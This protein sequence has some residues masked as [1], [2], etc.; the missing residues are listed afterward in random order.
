MTKLKAILLTATIAGATILDGTRAQAVDDWDSYLNTM[1]TK[2]SELAS[3]NNTIMGPLR[4]T[5]PPARQA[6]AELEKIANQPSEDIANSDRGRVVGGGGAHTAGWYCQRVAEALQQL[7]TRPNE[8]KPL[9]E[10]FIRAVE[11]PPHEF[12]PK[13]TE[14]L[15][16]NM[17]SIKEIVK[18]LA[19]IN[20]I[21][22]DASK[23]KQ[24]LNDPGLTEALRGLQG[25]DDTEKEAMKRVKAQDQKL[26]E[27]QG[28]VKNVIKMWNDDKR[29][30][31]EA[32]EDSMHNAPDKARQDAFWT[33]VGVIDGLKPP[34]IVEDATTLLA[35]A[36][37]LRDNANYNVTRAFEKARQEAK[38]CEKVKDPAKVRQQADNVREEYASTLERA[39]AFSIQ[40]RAEE[41][42]RVK[43]LEDT[44]KEVQ[45][46]QQTN[47][48]DYN[49]Q[50]RAKDLIRR[51]Q[52]QLEYEKREE[53]LL[54]DL[55]QGNVRK[56]ALAVRMIKF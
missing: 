31:H 18:R 2:I 49:F 11:R 8:P 45:A 54:A 42:K 19:D 26:D 55:A 48:G 40:R 3:P 24:A 1:R 17:P 35:R 33:L 14:R 5:L 16:A 37:K 36:G 30:L 53:Q 52:T 25:V 50:E 21:Q 10:Q 7:Q 44:I 27:L 12:P 6:A 29:R 51:T 22:T 38:D 23:L 43:G 56:A 34:S 32:A 9:A 4:K 28:A 41:Q 20:A 46:K 15:V 39:V 47:Q 13:S